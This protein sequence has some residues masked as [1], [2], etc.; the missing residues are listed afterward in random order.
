MCGSV[1]LCV[2]VDMDAD[3]DVYV[4][5]YVCVCVCRGS[6]EYEVGEEFLLRPIEPPRYLFVIDVTFTAIITGLVEQSLNAV[7][8]ALDEIS[9]RTLHAR[10]GV[11]TYSDKIDF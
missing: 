9:N 5:M 11:I 6:I 3:V 10:V 8:Y 1:D 7:R 4:C 2:D